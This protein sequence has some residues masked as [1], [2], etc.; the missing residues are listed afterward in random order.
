MEDKNTVKKEEIPTNQQTKQ[1]NKNEEKE[2]KSHNSNEPKQNELN[3]INIYDQYQK[4]NSQENEDKKN[5]MEHIA[6]PDDNLE[7]QTNNIEKTKRHRRGK[8]E[9]NERNYRCPDC[10][11]CY[12]SGPALT[13]HRKSKHSYGNNGEKRN[14]GRPKKEGTNENSQINPQNKFNSFFKDEN[15]QPKASEKILNNKIID[16]EVIKEF[17]QKI[18]NQWKDDLFK[19]KNNV[20]EY[21]FYGLMINNWEKENPF[22]N[23]EC[24]SSLFKNGEPSIK[25]DSY[26]LEEL[27]FFYLKEFSEKT[28]K[29]YFW[30]MIQFIILF[31]E[32][33]NSLR[34]NLIKNEDKS[35]NKQ[36][37]TEIYNA[38]TVPEIC[39]DFFVEFMEVK[40]YYGL[41]K[42]ELIELIQHFCYW[43][44]S[45]QYTQSHLTLL[46]N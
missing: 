20:E 7:K 12:L 34:K 27:F 43:L 24:Y 25:L 32:C 31:R 1:L 45:K 41:N 10:D 2:I 18:F 21:S 17:L 42:N 14:R 19:D 37:Y 15:R 38:E 9:I 44:Y 36:L 29:E 16:V 26:N 35:E 13:T 8:N 5:E 30:F 40:D 6:K 3:N 39:N 46:D 22:P 28:N 33:I 11:K 23:P 4:E